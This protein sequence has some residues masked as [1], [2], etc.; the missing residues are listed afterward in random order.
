MPIYEFICVCG[1]EVEEL[2]KMGDN[3]LACSKCGAGMIR[4]ISCPASLE[5]SK[6][7]SGYI[8]RSKGYKEG[9]KKEYLKS[10]GQ[11]EWRG[12]IVSS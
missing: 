7:D 4:K 2:K 6:D 9:Y 10:K 1:R 8:I 3:V 11:E 12:S 5:T